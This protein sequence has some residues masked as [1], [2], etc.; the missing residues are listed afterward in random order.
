M[1]FLYPSR[2][3]HVTLQNV[4][5]EAILYDRQHGQ[6]HVINSSAAR[7]WELCDGRTT[8]NDIV[9]AFASAYRIEPERVRDDVVSVLTAFGEL[10]LLMEAD[11]TQKDAC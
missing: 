11:G 1:E 8:L 6:A 9:T 3:P 4:G 10:H 7:I 2:S 5:K